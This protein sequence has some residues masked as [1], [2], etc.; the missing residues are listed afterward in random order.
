[1]KT[2]NQIE[3]QPATKPQ[4]NINPKANANIQTQI[5]RDLNQLS[6]LI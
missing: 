4:T 3:K 5:N 2:Y 1:M 6:N